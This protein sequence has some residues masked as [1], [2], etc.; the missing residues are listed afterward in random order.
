VPLF[1]PKKWINTL[2]SIR[3][4]LLP[5]STGSDQRESG[6]NLGSLLVAFVVSFTVAGSLALG[7]ALAYTAFLALLHAFAHNPP[8][9]ASRLVLVNSENHASGD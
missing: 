2:D 4:R 8:K 3:Y 7:I 6:P 1:T 9:P 5:E